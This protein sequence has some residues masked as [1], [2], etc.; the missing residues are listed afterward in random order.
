MQKKPT[1]KKITQVAKNAGFKGK[2]PKSSGVSVGKDLNG[3]FCYTHRARS[4]GYAT[5]ESI[6]KSVI[7]KIERTG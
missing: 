7:E 4:A 3:Y 1:S 5:Q 2:T 6:P